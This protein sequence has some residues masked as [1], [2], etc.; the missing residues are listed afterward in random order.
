M[1]E[2]P[3]AEMSAIV[4]MPLATASSA[5]MRA[6]SSQSSSVKNGSVWSTWRFHS[7]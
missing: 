5:P 3:D 2:T 4:V 6:E 7:A 1:R